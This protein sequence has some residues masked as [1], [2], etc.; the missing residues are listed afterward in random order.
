ME[1]LS[2]HLCQGW[3]EG[4]LLSG[5]HGLFA[6]YEA[7]AMVSSSM[8]VQHS[9]WLE[10][11]GELDWRASV[12]S[13]NILLTST[14]WRQDHNGFSHQGPG[15][16]DTVLSMQG[17]VTGIYLP[18]D[19]NCLLHVAN[20]CFRS[21]D[22][23][24]LLIIDKQ[25]EL[26][27][28]G[29]DEAGK[30]LLRG[31]SIWD[32]AGNEGAGSDVDVI[33]ACA[34]DVATQET[35]AAAWWLQRNVPEL[36][37]RVVNVIDLMSLATP[38]VHPH[39]M[40]DAEFVHLFTGDKPV[41][42]AFHGYRQA[43]H[44]ILHGRIN[45]GRFHVRGYRE[46]GTTTTPFMMVALNGMSRYQLAAEALRRSLRLREESQR[47]IQ[48]AEQLVQQAAAYAVDHLQDMPEISN[49]VWSGP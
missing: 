18:P 41:I 13:L 4:Y 29:I 17:T 47:L 15:L 34:G 35:V 5:R 1:V 27:W 28:L 12:A 16:I 2:E 31:A 9:K 22:H 40:S 21:R 42:F 49:W 26:Q 32:W 25:P 14:C 38:D 20:A 44:Q 7:F 10:A 46:Q 8:T 39:S 48:R 6:S 43:I 24:N 11:A 30:H 37:I 23:V 33:L 45:P 19:A 36:R 3:L